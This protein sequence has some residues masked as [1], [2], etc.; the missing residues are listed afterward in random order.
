MLTDIWPQYVE[1]AP[2]NPNDRLRAS[3]YNELASKIA[4]HPD[5]DRRGKSFEFYV[6]DPLHESNREHNICW[7]DG[8]KDATRVRTLAL[9]APYLA[10]GRLRN[11]HSLHSL[12]D[13]SDIRRHIYDDERYRH[14]Y[15]GAGMAYMDM[16]EWETASRDIPWKL[17][18]LETYS[19]VRAT[20]IAHTKWQ[21]DAFGDATLNDAGFGADQV[22][23]FMAER[24]A[25]K[26]VAG[27]P[28]YTAAYPVDTSTIRTTAASYTGPPGLPRTA[29][30]HQCLREVLSSDDLTPTGES[31]TEFCDRAGLASNVWY[32]ML[33]VFDGHQYYDRDRVASITFDRSEI[34]ARFVEALG[35]MFPTYACGMCG[36]TFETQRRASNHRSSCDD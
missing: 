27:I 24:T 28:E 23:A 1:A 26:W 35:E 3:S 15:W 34:E 13:V 17:D 18:A 22:N 25:E 7:V 5:D 30:Q 32:S 21:H 33:E 16:P 8:D 11:G 10:T 14:E 31:V 6:V 36:T 29:G 2:E 20:R 9:L 4:D 19:L 12:L